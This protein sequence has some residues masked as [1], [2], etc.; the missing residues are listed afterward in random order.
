[1][2]RYILACSVLIL[3]TILCSKPQIKISNSLENLN[4]FESVSKSDTVPKFDSSSLPLPLI[5][6]KDW[7]GNKF[8]V[9][10]KQ[11]VFCQSGYELFN[12]SNSDLS[13]AFVDSLMLSQ[14]NR[15][16]CDQIKGHSLT[17]TSVREIGE[18]WLVS[19]SDALTGKIIVGK[20]YRYSIKEILPENDLVWAKKRWLHNY[21]FSKKGSIS[22]LSEDRSSFGSIKVRVQDSLLVQD[23]VAGFTPLPVNPI[24][25]IVETG[26][27]QK[28][29]IA[30]RSS[31]TN[32]M[33]DKISQT[34]PWSSDIMETDPSKVFSW[35][36]VIWEII[37]NHRVVL[38]MS[39]DQVLLSWGEPQKRENTQ[40]SGRQLECWHYA[41]Q[42]LYF[43]QNQLI[44]IENVP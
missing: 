30:V 38:E 43:D 31:W 23:V 12:G 11:S 27:G 5:E 36:Q 16:P 33:S 9:L 3:L 39:R 41:A 19:F 37:N 34:D 6:L 15:I 10:E 21:V 44:A 20:T 2:K 25:L 29:I 7:I 22:S 24:W 35:D 17:V 14:N 26:L 18:E 1:M 40:Y 8:L 42:A 32:T 13:S 28:G 4:N